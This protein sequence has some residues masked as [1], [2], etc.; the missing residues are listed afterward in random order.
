MSMNNFKKLGITF[1]KKEEIAK[2][3][4]ITAAAILCIGCVLYGMD[5]GTMK[6][7]SLIFI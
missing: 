6:L 2:F 7:F 4:A 1:K 3:S 5:A